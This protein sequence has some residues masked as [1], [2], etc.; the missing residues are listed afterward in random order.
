MN[1]RK[2]PTVFSFLSPILSTYSR[3]L[4]YELWPL[5]HLGAAII[6]CTSK[7]TTQKVIILHV[8]PMFLG[9]RKGSPP[10]CLIER[11]RRRRQQPKH[12]NYRISATQ[13]YNK[14][15]T[16]KIPKNICVNT[17]KIS[18]LFLIFFMMTI[19]PIPF[20]S[21]APRRTWTRDTFQDLREPQTTPPLLCEN[22]VWRLLF[23]HLPLMMI[24]TVHYCHTTTALIA[25]LSD[26]SFFPFP[27]DVR[28]IGVG[29]L[30]H[31]FLGLD[32]QYPRNR[33]S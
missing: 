3:L 17:P 6:R 2:D 30:Q 21:T 28:G 24:Y 33:R 32:Q 26:S 15:K 4:H 7:K 11:R 10:F 5:L 1:K 18:K 19:F 27:L 16:T 12:P 8:H 13:K 31:I 22:D 14:N 9:I 25:N 23:G 29:V 20:T